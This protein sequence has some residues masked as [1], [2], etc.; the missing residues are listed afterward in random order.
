ME[1]PASQGYNRSHIYIYIYIIED[2][3]HK[4]PSSTTLKHL[5]ES[6]VGGTQGK[7]LAKLCRCKDLTL[8]LP[9]DRPF[10]YLW[11]RLG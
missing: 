10:P 9:E 8:M 2:S 5:E 3:A 6:N 1:I 7:S 11:D 4:L